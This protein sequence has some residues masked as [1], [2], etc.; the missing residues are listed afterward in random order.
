MSHLV[1]VAWDA[2]E[3][4][5]MDF[6]AWCWLHNIIIMILAKSMSLNIHVQRLLIQYIVDF[7]IY[8]SSINSYTSENACIYLNILLHSVFNLVLSTWHTP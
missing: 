2:Y 7:I 3:S 6:T 1:K 8:E 5:D 4:I